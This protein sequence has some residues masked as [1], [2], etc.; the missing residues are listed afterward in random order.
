MQSLCA[1]SISSS[2]FGKGYS[3]AVLLV[4]VEFRP[5]LH[6]LGQADLAA[7][8]RIESGLEKVSCEGYQ[9]VV[10]LQVL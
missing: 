3:F 5:P 6:P 10:A 4:P 1:N 7:R 2:G 9:D 8:L